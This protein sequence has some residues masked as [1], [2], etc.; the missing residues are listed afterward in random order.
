MKW[1]DL[2]AI[3]IASYKNV[4]WSVFALQ[5]ISVYPKFNFVFRLGR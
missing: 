5:P 1:C 3:T 2:Y 4:R